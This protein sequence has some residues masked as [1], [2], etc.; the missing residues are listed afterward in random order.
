M[1][2]SAGAALAVTLDRIAAS[3]GKQVIFESDIAR[4][5]RVAA[6]LD[7]RPPDLSGDARRKAAE[8]LVDQ[9]LIQREAADSR[10]TLAG[11]EDAARALEAARAQYGQEYP[12]AL[13]RYQITGAEL[14]EHL[15]A[16]IRMLRFTDA[17]FR[18]EIQVDQ[19]ELREF[20][21]LLAAGWRRD[22]NGEIPSFEQSR[23][24][25]EKLVLEQKTIQALDAWLASARS[26]AGVIF[27]D[28]V[29]E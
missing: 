21:Q 27:R 8:R 19:Q 14:R 5:A 10:L 15:L 29:L 9:L 12:D 22:G 6:F 7:Q 25:V 23:E 2:V 13:T 24:Q 18:P 3:V 11:E 26:Q 1:L 4:Y 20:Y 16:G 17:R 28:K